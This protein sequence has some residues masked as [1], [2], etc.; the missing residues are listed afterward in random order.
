MS[1]HGQ[2]CELRLT[3]V[4]PTVPNSGHDR[5]ELG[6][7]TRGDPV[8][9]GRG[10]VAG[11]WVGALASCLLLVAACSSGR[12]AEPDTTLTVPSSSVDTGGTTTSLSETSP[13]T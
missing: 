10:L 1:E 2:C 6:H 7:A 8:E 11:R 9:G 4:P 13:P 3:R 12:S 5:W